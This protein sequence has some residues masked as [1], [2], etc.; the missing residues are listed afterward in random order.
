MSRRRGVVLP[1]FL[2]KVGRQFFQ[3]REVGRATRDQMFD[4]ASTIDHPTSELSAKLHYE[5]PLRGEGRVG[6]SVRRVG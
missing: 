1:Q 4:P 3:G 6:T 2:C 5:R